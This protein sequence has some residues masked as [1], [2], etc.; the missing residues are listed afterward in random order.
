MLLL[1]VIVVPVSS[2]GDAEKPP[3]RNLVR[4]DGDVS[5]LGIGCF[6][7][8]TIRGDSV[9]STVGLSNRA[10]AE[11]FSTASDV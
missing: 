1:L 5:R 8:A 6:T 2:S 11:G 3:A 7:V 4:I 9:P 10:I